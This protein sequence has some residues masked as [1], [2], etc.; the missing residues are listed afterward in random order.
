MSKKILFFGNE[1]LA[2]GVTTKAPVFRA[3]IDSGYDIKALIISAPPGSNLYEEPIAKIA[4]QNNIQVVNYPS[5]AG[6]VEDISNFGVDTAVLAAYGKI[7]PE[8]ILRLFKNGIINVHPSLLPKHRGP[9][10]IESAILNGDKETGVSIMR[11]VKAM[12]AG[13]VFTQSTI[14]LKGSES[15]QELADK[16]GELGSKLLIDNLEGIISGKL[17]PKD[18]DSSLATYDKLISKE[19]GHIDWNQ[20][21]EIISRQIRAYAI[22]PR[23]TFKLAGIDII[24]TEVHIEDRQGKP[25]EIYLNGKTLGIYTTKGTLLIDRLIPTGKKEMNVESFIAG[26]GDRLLGR[27]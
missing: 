5:L 6:A 3:L 23:S 16:L 19:D 25:G 17:Q 20:A 7:V 24:V 21:A 2:T 10:P 14:S 12:D 18:Q 1:R 9:I 22:W 13:P 27:R 11:L 26:Y 15:K 4:K 8:S